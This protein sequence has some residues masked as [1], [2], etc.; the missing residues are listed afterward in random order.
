[1]EVNCVLNP[2]R[3]NYCQVIGLTAAIAL[4]GLL[5]MTEYTLAQSGDALASLSAQEKTSLKSGNALVEGKDGNYV[6]RILVTAPLDTAWEVLTD[7]D[8]FKKFLPG[9]VSSRILETQGNQV[10]FEQVTQVQL[11][12]LTQRTR[13]VI[14]AIKQYPQEITFQL[15]RGEIKSLK[16]SWKLEPIAPNQVL[17][18]Q[19]VAFDPGHQIARGLA[20]S[21]Y[22]NALADSLKAI[23]QETERRVR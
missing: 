14:T 6:S 17:I 11:L 5:P 20:F 7:Y 12:L 16:G 22:K 10:V 4:G 8:N 15:K 23:K 3:K 21:I 13:L 18:T 1:M 9:V 2:L 19:E